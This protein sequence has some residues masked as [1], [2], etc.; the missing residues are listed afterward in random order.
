MPWYQLCIYV[1][2]LSHQVMPVRA[3][4]I[5]FLHALDMVLYLDYDEVVTF[6]SMESTIMGHLATNVKY[7]KYF[8]TGELLRDAESKFKFGM[9]CDNVLNVIIVAMARA[10][11]LNLT[12]C[13]KE[14]KGSIQILKHA[15]D[16]TGKD[17]HLKFTENPPNVANNN[18]EAILLLNRLTESLSLFI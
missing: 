5:C 3:G 2:N 14:A 1:Y 13:Q 6:D 8:H 4:G 12:I 15:M 10:L 18:Y 7:Y 16:V 11:T 17:A 9:N